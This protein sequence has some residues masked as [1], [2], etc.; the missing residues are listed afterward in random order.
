MQ[1]SMSCL[2]GGSGIKE[3]IHSAQSL[4]SYPFFYFNSTGLLLFGN[5]E[6]RLAGWLEMPRLT[7]VNCL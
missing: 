2:V 4:L 5:K 1:G 6:T 7:A 3:R